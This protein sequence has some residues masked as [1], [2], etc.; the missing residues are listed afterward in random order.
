MSKIKIE[1]TAE[2]MEEELREALS[3]ALLVSLED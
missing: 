1:E 2:Q 3:Q